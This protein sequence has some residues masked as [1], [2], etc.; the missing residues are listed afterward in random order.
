MQAPRM[1]P[2]CPAVRAGVLRGLVEHPS[3][4][5]LRC[6]TLEPRQ[7]FPESWR[8]AFGIALVRRGFVVRQRV[9][10]LGRATALDALG[11]G[12]AMP[13]GSPTDEGATGYA[14]SAAMV[15]LCPQSECD[16]A[17][18]GASGVARDILDAQSSMLER[19]ERIADARGRPRAITR[20]ARLLC[21]L[22][23]TLCAS[24]RLS[25][26]PADLQQRDLAALL[27]LRHESVCRAL[28]SLEK[29]HIIHRD[30]Q[31]VRILDRTALETI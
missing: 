3:G 7:A 27:A 31:G 5:A 24:R 10:S 26:I 14:A 13:V 29:K 30:P 22:S 25:L 17:L 8:G 19:V 4:C 18:D 9:D 23:D 1:C 6:A 21:T 20:V 11:P 12:S 15:C 28:G 16:R 2:D